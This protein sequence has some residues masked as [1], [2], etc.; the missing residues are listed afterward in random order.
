VQVIISAANQAASE[1][2]AFYDERYNQSC[3]ARRVLFSEAKEAKGCT[4]EAG[5][6]R[7]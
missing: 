5:A 2:F 3:T 1:W 7:E 4:A 6:L